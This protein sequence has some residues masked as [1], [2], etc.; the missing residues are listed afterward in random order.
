[1]TIVSI[2]C[3]TMLVDTALRED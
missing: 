2:E 1:M 3:R